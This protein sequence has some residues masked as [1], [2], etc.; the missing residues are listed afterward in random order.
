MLIAI[1]S[2][3]LCPICLCP[4][5]FLD[6]FPFA[7]LSPPPSIY[8]CI[9]PIAFLVTTAAITVVY[10]AQIRVTLHVNNTVIWADR[11]GIHLVPKFSDLFRSSNWVFKAEHEKVSVPICLFTHP[12]MLCKNWETFFSPFLTLFFFP[13][14]QFLFPPWLCFSSPEASH[15]P[16]N[17]QHFMHALMNSPQQRVCRATIRRQNYVEVASCGLHLCQT[18]RDLLTKSVSSALFVSSATPCSSAACGKPK[19]SKKSPF[20]IAGGQFADA[21]EWPW[22]ASIRNNG[23]HMC[24]GSLIAPKWL[25]SAA[26]CF[27]EW[28]EE[29]VL[30]PSSPL[31]GDRGTVSLSVCYNSLLRIPKWPNL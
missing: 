26:H 8:L 16:P 9:L 21:G 22:Q 18:A 1:A 15:N 2:T 4:H 24:A 28:V 11:C 31:G 17:S 5:L 20:R 29:K 12:Q 27:D 14:L 3:P 30:R 23:L 19:V 7:S 13:F 10:D 25:V 6:A